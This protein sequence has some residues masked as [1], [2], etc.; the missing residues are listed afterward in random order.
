MKTR[1]VFYFLLGTFFAKGQSG[2]FPTDDIFYRIPD[3]NF[4]QALIETYVPECFDSEQNISRYCASTI[5]ILNV[6]SQDIVNISG[7]EHFTALKHFE[8]NNNNLDTLKDLPNSIAYLDC[9]GNNIKKLSIFPTDLQNLICGSKALV[10][11]SNLPEKLESLDCS[12]SLLSS[13]PNL[14]QNLRKLN[15]SYNNISFFPELESTNLWDLDCSNNNLSFLPK[16]PQTLQ[17]LSCRNNSINCLPFLP[18]MLFSLSSDVSCIP[19][20][21]GLNP[22]YYYFQICN[23]NNNPDNCQLI[24][25]TSD[26]NSLPKNTLSFPNPVENG[27]LFVSNSKG[28]KFKLNN[29]KGQL[30]MNGTVDETGLDV[31]QLNPGMYMLEIGTNE[32]RKV[33]KI[34]IR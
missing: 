29:A 30:M 18:N 8:C 9:S 21:A 31:S 19:N 3:N 2:L 11:I 4:R 22:T 5:E 28:L 27:R 6:N 12:S 1:L 7:I 26:N 32:N 34:V 13:L 10:Y 14:N 23:S 20:L 24:T 25:S 15:C 16:L 17:K 33:E